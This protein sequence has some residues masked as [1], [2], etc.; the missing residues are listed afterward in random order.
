MKRFSFK[1][2]AV[3]SAV[4]AV[5]WLGCGDGGGGGENPA[6]NNTG[7]NNTPGNNNNGGDATHDG[8]LI[9][10]DGEAWVAWRGGDG[11][12]GSENLRIILTS[13]G[14]YIKYEREDGVWR[15]RRSTWRTEGNKLIVGSSSGHQYEVSDGKLKVFEDNR[16]NTLSKCNG[17]VVGGNNNT[18]GGSS[19]TVSLGGLKWMKKNLN[20]AAEDSWCYD[21][22]P[23]SCAKYGRLYTWESSKTACQS[24][25]MR[26][27]TRDEWGALVS[28]AG[29]VE[30]AGKKLKSTSG[31]NSWRGISSTDEFGFS[32]LPGG[33]RSSD[34]D[35]GSAGDLGHW[36]L[37][38]ERDSR[39]AYCGSMYYNDDIAADGG[40]G[41]SAGYS[42]RCVKN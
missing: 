20:V 23:D 25:G 36:W 9:N 27:P 18:G 2:L 13:D 7:G 39:T 31:W 21:G 37:A 26:L 28:A 15:E 16:W 32:A 1:M 6:N 19:E 11:E 29:G 3:A 33:S 14:V 24:V 17:V 35:F 40:K 5:C 41:T 42:V 38:T 4:C 8:R 30:I 22:S 34:G 12:C 10:A